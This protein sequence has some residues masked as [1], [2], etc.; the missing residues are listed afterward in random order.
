MFVVTDLPFIVGSSN[1]AE[2]KSSPRRDFCGP[3]VVCSDLQP[4]TETTSAAT[5]APNSKRPQAQR[6][7]LGPPSSLFLYISLSSLARPLSLLAFAVHSSL[8]AA[9]CP[10]CGCK[11]LPFAASTWYVTSLSPF[12][13]TCRACLLKN[14][15]CLCGEVSLLIDRTC[16]PI[17]P[18]Q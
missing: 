16:E 7:L 14:L 13:S 10:L 3:T 4:R 1:P 12:L 17:I 18:L 2:K 15:C 6:G 9:W 8:W 11:P 5:R